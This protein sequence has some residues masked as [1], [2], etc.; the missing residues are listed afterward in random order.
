ML[1]LRAGLTR[2]QAMNLAEGVAERATGSVW[3]LFTTRAGKP[4]V[5]AT[6][7]SGQRCK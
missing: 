5:V 6:W 3:V 1:P 4:L 2:E 7:R